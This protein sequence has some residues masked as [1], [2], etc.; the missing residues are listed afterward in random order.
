M[1]NTLNPYLALEGVNGGTPCYYAGSPDASC[2]A[3]A[4]GDP[5]AVIANPYYGSKITGAQLK[6]QFP[7]TAFYPTYANYFPYGLQ[8]GDASTIIPPNVFSGYLSWKHHK[9]QATLTGN[10]WE[11]QSYGAPVE[12]AGIDPRSCIANQGAIGVVPGSQLGDYQT[13]SSSIAIPNPYTGQ[14]DGIGQYR[15]PWELNLGAQIGYDLSPRVHASLL[16]ANI[17]NRC[18]G[19]SKEP[20]TT[21]YPPNNVI[22]AYDPNGGYVGNTP[23]AGYFYGN[24]PHDAVNGTAGYPKVFDQAYAPGANQISSPFQAYFQLQVRL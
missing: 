8:A 23:G 16:L 9:L 24:S 2:T 15:D 4:G 6:A 17:L 19:G 5:G 10:L 13:C 3:P 1:L 7:L 22:C 14:F 18:F 21:A 12:I 20:W 11:G